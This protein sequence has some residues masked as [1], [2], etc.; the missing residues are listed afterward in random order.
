[1]FGPSESGGISDVC[2]EFPCAPQ[3]PLE[4]AKYYE[5]RAKN[6]AR[7]GELCQEVLSALRTRQALSGNINL[8]QAEITAYEKRLARL[9]RKLE[10][11]GAALPGSNLD[12]C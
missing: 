2:R 7:A 1:M 6:I 12:A 5:H 8:C 9:K 3:P 10:R 4:L 11:A